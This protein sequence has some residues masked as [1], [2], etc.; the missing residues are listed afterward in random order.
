MSHNLHGGN[1]PSSP[2]SYDLFPYPFQL[3]H[4]RSAKPTLVFIK[5]GERPWCSPMGLEATSPHPNLRD[6]ALRLTIKNLSG[7]FPSSKS[8]LHC[9]CERSKMASALLA[10]ERAWQSRFSPPPNPYTNFFSKN[11]V[12]IDPPYPIKESIVRWIWGRWRQ[13]EGVGAENIRTSFE[14]RT[15]SCKFSLCDK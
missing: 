7:V 8:I 1:S 3:R 6:V 4:F 13:P 12:S 11:L 14:P 2:Y 15:H 5:V 10:T 9:H